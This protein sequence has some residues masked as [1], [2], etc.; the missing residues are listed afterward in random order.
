MRRRSSSHARRALPYTTFS[1]PEER[2]L[3]FR[4]PKKIQVSR[5]RIRT[6]YIGVHASSYGRLGFFVT[7]GDKH[8]MKICDE[9]PHFT[10]PRISLKRQDSAKLEMRGR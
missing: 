10:R 9:N 2:S 4:V 7:G 5:N 3:S 1:R 6:F 8:L